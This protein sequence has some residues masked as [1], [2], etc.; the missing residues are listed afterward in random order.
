LSQIQELASSP[1][2]GQLRFQSAAGFST[3]AGS[4]VASGSSALDPTSSQA[5]KSP[6]LAQ[7]YY[8]T[9]SEQEDNFYDRRCFEDIL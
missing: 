5:R 1:G 4:G 6:F 2:S 7:A 8:A 9:H 3:D